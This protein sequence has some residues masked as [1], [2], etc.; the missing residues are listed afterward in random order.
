MLNIHDEEEES[1]PVK[2]APQGPNARQRMTAT[3]IAAFDVQ[4]PT[5]LSQG[6]VFG[7]QMKQENAALNALQPST[8][9]AVKAAPVL[10]LES[11]LIQNQAV[12]NSDNRYPLA[13]ANTR[14]SA[15]PANRSQSNPIRP[16][17]VGH[18]LRSTLGSSHRDL[19]KERARE[20]Q[21]KEEPGEAY[22][23]QEK[24]MERRAIRAGFRAEMFMYLQKARD[25]A[26]QGHSRCS[27][28]VR[29]YLSDR[30]TW[31]HFCKIRLTC[32]FSIITFKTH[33]L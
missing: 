8:Q 30:K 2:I 7:T 13:Y 3:E 22:M 25:Q 5:R 9:S 31:E 33:I 12:G 14:D 29:G 11:K 10:R 24:E 18:S 27:R 19:N 23:N 28:Y 17:M 4:N 20:R 26:R 6:V 32:L 1:G 21:T 16:Q 15:A